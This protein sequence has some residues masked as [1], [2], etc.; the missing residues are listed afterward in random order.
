MAE[1]KVPETNIKPS[2]SCAKLGQSTELEQ[3][4]NRL[5]LSVCPSVCVWRELAYGTLSP[6]ATALSPLLSSPL[7]RSHQSNGST[8]ET[9]VRKL[10]SP[11]LEEALTATILSGSHINNMSERLFVTFF[12]LSFCLFTTPKTQIVYRVHPSPIR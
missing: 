2:T 6:T 8:S 9:F 11:D 1:S 3:G 10:V 4:I 12:Y 7:P 5:Y